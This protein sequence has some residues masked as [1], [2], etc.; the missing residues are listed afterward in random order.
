MAAAATPAATGLSTI[1]VGR[2]GLIQLILGGQ[3]RGWAH[4]LLTGWHPW[5][6]ERH[7]T[8]MTAGIFQGNSREGEA[9]RSFHTGPALAGWTNHWNGGDGHRPSRLCRHRLGLPRGL[10]VRSYII[11][12]DVRSISLFIFISNIRSTSLCSCI[13]SRNSKHGTFQLSPRIY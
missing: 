11:K 7:R 10:L 12:R 2:G 4:P 1:T 9:N 8:G 5:Q 13:V 6:F 3:P